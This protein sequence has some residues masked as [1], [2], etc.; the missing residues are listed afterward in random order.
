MLHMNDSRPADGFA[1]Y[2][3]SFKDQTSR[4]TCHYNTV[5]D[6]VEHQLFDHF[7][8]FQFASKKSPEPPEVEMILQVDSPAGAEEEEEMEV[9]GKAARWRPAYTRWTFLSCD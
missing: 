6:H 3:M 2:G 9:D 8:L 4:N 5:E 1:F 7:L